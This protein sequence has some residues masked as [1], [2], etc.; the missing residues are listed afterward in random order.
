MK[1]KKTLQATDG[2][3]LM[4]VQPIK[5]GCPIGRSPLRRPHPPLGLPKMPRK[6]PCITAIEHGATRMDG[7]VVSN[8]RRG[9]NRHHQTINTGDIE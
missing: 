7:Q 9:Y 5:T 6:V 3:A 1:A 4:P 8:A 2:V